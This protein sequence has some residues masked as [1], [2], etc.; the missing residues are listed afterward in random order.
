[1]LFRI[2]SYQRRSKSFFNF[3]QKLH[4]TANCR[5][6]AMFTS[7][8]SNCSGKVYV[9]CCLQLR[10]NLD[11]F[12]C[13]ILSGVRYPDFKS[14]VANH[15]TFCLKCKMNCAGKLNNFRGESIQDVLPSFYH[16]LQFGYFKR[17]MK[18][19]NIQLYF[20]KFLF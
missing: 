14:S 18:A 16:Y 3:N 1:M 17:E 10:W 15:F 5:Y 13:I 19:Y 4:S 6:D 2:K 11:S 9:E 12:E 7:V 20:V 8:I